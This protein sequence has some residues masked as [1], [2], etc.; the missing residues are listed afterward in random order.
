MACGHF[1]TSYTQQCSPDKQE[2]CLRSIHHHFVNDTCA[3][4]DP[5]VKRK[6]VCVNYKKCHA[7]LMRE[8]C[9]AKRAQDQAAMSRIE[10]LMTELVQKVRVDNFEISLARHDPDVL[11]SS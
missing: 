5:E 3:Q 7:R 10:Q 2:D 11:W 6:E 1:F 4:C 8:Y 9:E